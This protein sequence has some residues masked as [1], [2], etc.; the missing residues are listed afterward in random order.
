MYF[1]SRMSGDTSYCPVIGASCSYE[2]LEVEPNSFFL[3]QPFDKEKN[4][5][6]EAI[7]KALEKFYG[8]GKYKLKKS[9]SHVHLQGS[10]CDIC[11]K[12]RSCQ[13]CIADMTG[14]IFKVILE[15]EIKDRVF[16]RPNVAFELGLA[17]GLSKPSLVLFKKLTSNYKIPSDIDFVRY[18]DIEAKNWS[19]VSQRILDR[20]KDG[21]PNR[22]IVNANNWNELNT[23]QFKKEL[24]S[25]IH[26]KENLLHM[27]YKKFKINQILYKNSRLLCIIKNASNLIES[28]YF[29]LYVTENDIEEKKGLI[30]IN[31]INSEKGIAQAEIIVG[32]FL[33]YWV[34]IAKICSEKGNFILG[35]H[36]L[37]VTIPQQ[38]EKLNI[39]ELKSLE[40]LLDKCG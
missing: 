27:K 34:N 17:Y 23:A 2:S 9:D 35:E 29:Y 14:E 19:M 16:W 6:E 15:K 7:G 12:I 26:Q 30:R 3:I 22:S 37:E 10:Y 5:R 32:D 11:K 39:D 13:Y 8:K 25:V 36:R 28:T 24:K 1:L 4:E 33:D 31:S 18:V 21:A 20:L 38:L 40:S